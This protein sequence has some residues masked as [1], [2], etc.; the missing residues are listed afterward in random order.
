M[1]WWEWRVGKIIIPKRSNRCDSEK[2]E[3][4]VV[5]NHHSLYLHD[6]TL[7]AL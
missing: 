1:A 5:L 7:N 6:N 2:Q 3:E 4:N